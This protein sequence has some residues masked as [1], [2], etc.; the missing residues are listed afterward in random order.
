[1]AEWARL[2]AGS[3]IRGGFER[4][5]WYPVHLRQ[6]DGVIWLMGPDETTAP[7]ERELVRV[8]DGEPAVVTRVPETEFQPIRAG[9]PAAKLRFYGICPRGH[10]IKNVGETD[11]ETRCG[12]CGRTWAVE[13]EDP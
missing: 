6:A 9:E 4:G 11:A 2:R 1:M 10:F 12:K 5:F 3:T 8:I 13:N 7:I